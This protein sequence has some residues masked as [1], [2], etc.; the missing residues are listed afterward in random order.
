[1]KTMLPM[2]NADVDASATLPLTTA[3][4]RA[5]DALRALRTTARDGALER[6]RRSAREGLMAVDGSA[7]RELVRGAA[8]VFMRRK[9]V[10]DAENAKTHRADA[11]DDERCVRARTIARVR[12]R[13]TR[14]RA[15]VISTS[16]SAAPS[17]FVD[18]VRATREGCV[19]KTTNRRASA[20]FARRTEDER[21]GSRRES[22]RRRTRGGDAT[23]ATATTTTP[24]SRERSA[25][26]TASKGGVKETTRTGAVVPL[27]GGRADENEE[28]G[29]SAA[30]SGDIAKGG[31]AREDKDAIRGGDDA[32]RDAGRG[33]D[34][35]DEGVDE[36][37]GEE[38]SRIS[39][40]F[41]DAQTPK[42]VKKIDWQTA[43]ASASKTAR[44]TRKSVRKSAVKRTESKATATPK[45]I[46]VAADEA[47]GRDGASTAS[48]QSSDKKKRAK[49]RA[50]GLAFLKADI[51]ALAAQNPRAGG[52]VASTELR[53]SPR[54]LAARQAKDAAA[55]ATPVA[56]V[57]SNVD[58]PAAAAATAAAVTAS[59]EP[60]TAPKTAGPAAPRTLAP[61][62]PVDQR[63]LM[64]SFMI[65][66]ENASASSAIELA[67]L[68]VAKIAPTPSQVKALRKLGEKV[69]AAAAS[70]AAA[71]GQTSSTVKPSKIFQSLPSTAEA[72]DVMS[73]LKRAMEARSRADEEN[74][75]Q[76]ESAL[77][78]KEE[79]RK[80]REK[81][82]EARKA[83]QA[84]VEAREREERR[85]RQERLAQFRLQEEEAQRKAML[86]KSKFEKMLQEQYKMMSENKLFTSLTSS[87]R[88]S[89][90][91]GFTTSTAEI[92]KRRRLLE[93]AQAAINGHA[94]PA[95]GNAMRTPTR[96]I[97]KTNFASSS[98]QR[99]PA[100][101]SYPISPYCSSDSEDDERPRKVIPN[102]ARG[103]ALVPQLKAQS[104]VD[105]DEIF[106]NPSLTCSLGKIFKKSSRDRRRSSSNW[107]HDR[108]TLQEELSYKQKMGFR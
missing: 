73:R 28:R 8:R 36:A 71:L 47:Q 27:D 4:R 14:H 45:A 69:T 85:L 9:T 20:R 78:Q 1:M 101:E 104:Y 90:Q 94:Q 68:S 42:Y 64:E 89:G 107:A 60:L 106:P 84:S 92:E 25:V 108:L 98:A 49:A 72:S 56:L 79:E 24:G 97:F 81:E 53:I 63:S 6:V 83:K 34:A 3:S 77:R 95:S 59:K 55:E 86:E 76:L 65:Q 91:A 87:K 74:K 96:S 75:R 35:G 7:A 23:V 100:V 18:G 5:L 31:D 102:W 105:P 41:A 93:N 37:A 38:E 12:E 22:R 82:M 21:A 16:P 99:T 57:S 40:D 33:D 61:K 58:V 54:T 50:N 13:E 2:K 10:E 48:A 62:Q 67:P 80:R 11:R 43:T 15:R 70:T 66:P 103:E 32:T 88:K 29:K 51:P 39:R 26:K 52:A 19:A 17:S 30:T 44:S 46:E